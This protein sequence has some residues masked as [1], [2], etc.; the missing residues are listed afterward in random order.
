MDRRN[1]TIADSLDQDPKLVMGN[2]AWVYNAAATIH[3][4]MI[5]GAGV[6]KFKIKLLPSCRRHCENFAVDLC[7]SGDTPDAP[8]LCAKLP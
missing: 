4:G 3:Q 1:S 2:L 6:I 5:T 8:L 7:S